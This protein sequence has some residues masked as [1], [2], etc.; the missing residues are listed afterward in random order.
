MV[1]KSLASRPIHPQS[2][3][4]QECINNNANEFRYLGEGTYS[5]NECAVEFQSMVSLNQ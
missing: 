2:C 1:T 4:S 3:I 5:C